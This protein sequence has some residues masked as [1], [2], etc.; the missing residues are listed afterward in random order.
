ML[1]KYRTRTKLQ[2]AVVMEM[3]GIS[4]VVIGAAGVS[5]DYK[6]QLAHILTGMGVAV[7]AAWRYIK[8]EGDIDKV[9][10]ITQLLEELQDED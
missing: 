8:S 10:K 6:V 2:Q 4:S 7:I 5:D 1:E 3:L 9:N